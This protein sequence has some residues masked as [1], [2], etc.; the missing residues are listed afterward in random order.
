MENP[1]SE[2]QIKKISEI[3]KLP[4]EQQQA[5][6]NNFARTLNEEQIKFLQEQQQATA[7]IFCKIADG[8]IKSIKVYEDNEIIAVLDIKPANIGH[9]LVMPK[10]HFPFS[11]M[12]PDELISKMFL[13]ANK[14]AKAVFEEAK[15]EGTNIF[16][17]NGQTAGQMM[18]HTAVNVIPRFKND[19]VAFEWGSIKADEKELNILAEKM[20]A[21]VNIKKAEKIEIKD[22]SNYEYSLDDERAP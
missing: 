8:S 15:A 22:A 6:W 4:R 18:Q 21:K 19:K 2:D 1:L 20:K 10:K 3:A 9:T 11:T 7:C 17:A 16:L 12:M 5:E 13:I 14:I